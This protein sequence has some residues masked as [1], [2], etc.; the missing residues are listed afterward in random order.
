MLS[1]L[2]PLI[3]LYLNNYPTIN[4]TI[5][6][7]ITLQYRTSFS[8]WMQAHLFSLFTPNT[9][10]KTTRNG[11]PNKFTLKKYYLY[12]KICIV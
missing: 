10:L 4:T 6:Y 3:L 8:F 12:N 1:Y 11:F 7:K 9:I 5:V 2:Y